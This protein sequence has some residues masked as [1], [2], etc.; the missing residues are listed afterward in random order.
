MREGLR[1]VTVARGPSARESANGRDPRDQA[2]IA[3]VPF[4]AVR[5]LLS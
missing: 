1:D 4:V 3:R 2:T 5:M